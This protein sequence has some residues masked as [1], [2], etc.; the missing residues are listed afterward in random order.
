MARTRDVQ[1]AVSYCVWTEVLAYG[2]L[3]AARPT[4]SVSALHII[5]GYEA[6]LSAS[7]IIE[8]SACVKSWK[9]VVEEG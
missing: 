7:M 9:N 6:L 3:R 1:E 4:G 2:G 5:R 8:C